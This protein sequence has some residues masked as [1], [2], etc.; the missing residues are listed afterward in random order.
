M[1]LAA[2]TV[3]LIWYFFPLR[4]EYPSLYQLPGARVTLNRVLRCALTMRAAMGEASGEWLSVV[5]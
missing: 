1:L 3:R 4:L 5:R 2:N